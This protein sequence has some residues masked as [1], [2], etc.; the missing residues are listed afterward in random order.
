[1][2]FR[3]DRAWNSSWR[4]E[5]RISP[6]FGVVV[7]G[8]GIPCPVIGASGEEGGFRRIALLTIIMEAGVPIGVLEALMEVGKTL[9][10]GGVLMAAGKARTDIAVI[11]TR[12]HNP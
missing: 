7:V 10:G 12:A 5:R 6:K 1:M 8:A 3:S 2:L 11:P 4:R 9:T